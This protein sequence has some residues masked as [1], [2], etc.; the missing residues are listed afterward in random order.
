MA[1]NIGIN[2]IET[3][4]R[5]ARTISAAPVSV[6]AFLVRSLR[7]VPNVPVTVRGF[8]DFTVNFGGYSENL[9]GAFAV[10]GFFDNGGTEAKIVRLV[11]SGALA[12]TRD[13]NDR[14]GNP[15]L[16]ISAGVRGRPDPGAWGNGLR[17]TMQDHP[18]GILEVPAQVAGGTA[19]P[20]ALANGQTLD[21]TVNGAASPVT[22]T[23][24]TADFGNIA[25]ATAAEV[26]SSIRRQTTAFRAAALG[27][28]R[29]LLASSIPGPASRLAI[30]GTAATALGFTGPTAN[31]DAGIAAGAQNVIAH[32]T[33][34]VVAGSAIRLESRGL[35]VG[36]AAIGAAMPANGGI[37]VAVDGGA[38]IPIDFQA[39]DFA[40][41]FAAI[42][43]AEAVAAINR[44]ANGFFAALR[45]DGLLVIAS[46]SFGLGSSIAIGAGG[47]DATAALGLTGNVPEAGVRV[48]RAVTQVSE[49][50][51]L[52]SWTT[53]LGA[54]LVPLAARIQSAEFDLAVSLNGVEVERFESLSMQDGLAFSATAVINDEASGSRYVTAVDLNSGA[55]AAED[56]PAAIASGALTT[57]GADGAA[58][59]DAHYLGDA[60]ART[61]YH[62]LD[63]QSVQLL[64]CP[65]TT[66][67]G[68]VTAALAYCENRGDLMFVG[69]APQLTPLQG[70][71]NYASAFRARKVFGALYAPWIQVVNPLDQ[72][73]SNPLR[74]IPPTGHVLGAYA[75][76]AETR[77]VW[78][79]PAGDEARLANA[80]AVE[81]D[82]TD[83]DHTNLVRN[84]GV[85]GV[86]AVPGAG[87]IIDASRTLSSDSRWLF[88]GTR[89]LFNF[90]KD[91]V[92]EGL[93]FVAQEP[94]SEALRRTV[95]FN[96]VTPFLLGLWRQGAFGNDPPDQVFTVVCDASNNP[97]AEV[98][99]GNFRIEI[100]FYPVKPAE[101]ILITVGQQESAASA[102]EA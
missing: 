39:A 64:A 72:D 80:L 62:A 28:G 44:R 84:G 65:E 96:V 85:N 18:R 52:I 93:R 94:N 53:G 15:T 33:G 74:W 31:T 36:T 45:H 60:G 79:A 55:G 40:G 95:R 81:F 21:V 91:S 8:S 20:F 38:A 17:I 57:A 101:S 66:S 9:F 82:M 67:P 90:I 11:G 71:I 16:R 3:D 56:V 86:R 83:T 92:R 88:V 54:A 70:V 97:P 27:N 12:A 4:G 42:T 100:Y 22:V 13:F 25:S 73:G 47:V 19:G 34:G 6:A 89:R 14:A 41:G 59:L 46:N 26:A 63:N 50:Y 99:L 69:T 87:I 58:P 32:S 10:R 23:F 7:G 37:T 75:R 43:A 5:A 24:V 30:T 35:T 78:K 2:L 29:L 77:G 48:N 51:R 68:A 102:D 98:T 76:I 61:G 1:T 49:P